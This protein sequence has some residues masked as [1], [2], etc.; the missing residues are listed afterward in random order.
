MCRWVLVLQHVGFGDQTQATQQV[1]FQLLGHLTNLC[2]YNVDD[3]ENLT[4]EQLYVVA[5]LPFAYCPQ[6]ACM[7]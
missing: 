7:L 2:F 5:F 6:V 1:P 3:L 4:L